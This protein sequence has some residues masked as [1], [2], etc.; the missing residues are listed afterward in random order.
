M[1]KDINVD[2]LL[3]SSLKCFVRHSTSTRILF[4]KFVALRRFRPQV[5]LSDNDTAERQST[6]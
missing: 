4:V 1:A 3:L 2:W 6:V 5:W